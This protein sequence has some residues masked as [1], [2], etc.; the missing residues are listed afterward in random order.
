MDLVCELSKK[1]IKP[2][3]PEFNGVAPEIMRDRR[4]YP[5]FKDCIGAIDGVH[6]PASICDDE[7]TPYINRKGFPS[8]NVMAVCNFDMQFIFV[9]AG[10]EGSA[11]DTRVLQSILRNPNMNFPHPPPCNI[12]NFSQ[13]FH[14]N[15]CFK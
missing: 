2:E 7:K 14:F 6:I 13:N 4:Y 12:F 8:Q 3:D 5:Y 10:W 15:S 1:I 11:H 9:C